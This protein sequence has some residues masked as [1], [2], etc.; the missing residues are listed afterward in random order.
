MSKS[1]KPLWVKLCVDYYE[2]A[3]IEQ[4]SPLA[5]LMWVR[6]LSHAKNDNTG[7]MS[8]GTVKR[9]VFD[10]ASM[11]F[12][13]LVTEL[14]DAGLWDVCDGSVTICGWSDWQVD[15]DEVE[16]TRIASLRRNHVRWHEKRDFVDSSCSFCVESATDSAVESVMESSV[17]SA[18]DSSVESKSR[19]R[20]DVETD[21]DVDV[22]KDISLV[23]PTG[24]KT[25][26]RTTS[27]GFNDF[28]VKYP[29]KV[30]KEAARKAWRSTAKTRPPLEDVL[31]TLDRAIE[32][33]SK[34]E[35]KFIP[36]PATWLNQGRWADETFIVY[37]EETRSQMR[38]RKAM[39]I[40][41]R[42]E[43]QEQLDALKELGR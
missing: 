18:V 3:K 41:R 8:L 24:N 7:E 9:A 31:R 32:A 43:E 29:K 42:Y 6:V 37:A 1:N 28:W 21:V 34:G 40:V 16:R 2:D 39:E 17:D 26:H 36:H 23:L 38:D 35:A 14:V 20:V 25:L 27:D 15:A 33:W 13:S 12:E 11:D 22:D 10:F 19:Q 4:L 5:E 30:G